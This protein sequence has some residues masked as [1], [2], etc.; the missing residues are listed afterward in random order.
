MATVLV[1][2]ALFVA[3]VYAVKPEFVAYAVAAT[4]I[5][6]GFALL[7]DSGSLSPTLLSPRSHD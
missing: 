7:S 6:S 2:S 5:L 4:G 1:P 3:G